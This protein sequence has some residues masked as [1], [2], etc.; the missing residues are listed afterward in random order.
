MSAFPGS[1]KLLRGGIVVL[2]PGTGT[3]LRTIVLQYNPDSISRTLAIQSHGDGGGD[4]SQALRLKGPAAET[5]KLDAELDAAD[6]LEK[7]ED[8]PDVVEHGLHP[9]IA[10]LEALVNPSADS[11]VAIHGRAGSGT[12]EIIPAL[13]PFTVF[14]WG[15]NRI[16]PVRVTELSITEEAFDPRLNPI[17]AKVS[18]GLRV[19]TVADVG[20]DNKLGNLFLSHLRARESLAQKLPA[21]SLGALGIGGL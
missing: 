7:P 3:V 6:F 13:A 17:R 20:F 2:D 10:A 5:L 16:Q 19:L 18:L 11:L 14:V 8:S 21:G 1:P 4:P 12:L 15:G 9:Q